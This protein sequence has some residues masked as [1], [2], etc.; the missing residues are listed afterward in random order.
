MLFY[1][2]FKF[3]FNF[4]Y[5][6]ILIKCIGWNCRSLSV[7]KILYVNY[8]IESYKPA[9][10]I[11]C[12]TWLSKLPTWLD[13]R[14]DIYKTVDSPHQ[15]VWIL[16]RKGLVVKSFINNEPFI[17]AVQLVSKQGT[18]V[19]GTYLKEKSKSSDTRS[20]TKPNSKNKKKIL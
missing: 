13:K 1:L 14:F 19:I 8:L 20:A 10:F 15:G 6:L 4:Q 17:I 11:L 2:Y 5:G 9:I 12:E 16:A 18:F 3:V 7:N